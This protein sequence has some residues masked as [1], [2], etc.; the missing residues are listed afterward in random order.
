MKRL[1]IALGILLSASA[2]ADP[3]FAPKSCVQTQQDLCMDATPCKMISGINACLN[4]A[5]LPN[6]AVRVNASCW[7][8][9]AAFTCE[10]SSSIDTCQPL[11]DRGCGQIGTSC[12]N[13]DPS[14]KCGMANFTY[15]CPDKPASTK[16]ET[17]CDT[18]FCKDGTGCFDTTS[19]PDRDFGQAAALVEVSREAGVYGIKNGN[20]EVFKGYADE[21][22]VKVLGGSTIKSCCTKEPGGAAFTNNAVMSTAISAGGAVGKEALKAGSKYV[23]DSLYQSLDSGLMKD[24]LSSMGSSLGLDAASMGSNF[25]AYGFQFSFSMESGFGFVGFDPTSFAIA[26]A[27]MVIQKWLACDSNEQVLS[28]KKGQ[29]LCVYTGSYCS[30]KVLGFCVEKKEKSCCFN[31]ILAKIVNVQGRL[32]LGLPSD[33]CGGF[34]QAQIQALDFTKMDFSE[35]IASI[36]TPT[37]NTGSLTNQIN[38]TVQKK[39]TDYYGQ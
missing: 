1:L 34:N 20:I 7:Q 36:V 26:I 22:S 30:S 31:S 5:A 8:Y 37:P 3:S 13:T 21:C 38:S 2:M 23:Y 14:G 29:N 10:D 16:Q 15:S 25:G 11:R 9:Q 18:S 19:P 17:I 32:Q 27:I 24:G 6:G 35:F 4:G 12:L 33:Q 28:M 39:V